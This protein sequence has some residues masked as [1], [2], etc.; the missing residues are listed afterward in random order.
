MKRLMTYCIGPETV[1]LC[2]AV[3]TYWICAR[4]NSGQGRDVDLL[5]KLVMALPF[6]I[7]PIVFA[8]VFVPGARNGWWLGRAV[9][10]TMVGMLVLAGRLISGFGMG[11][12]GQDVAFMMVMIF[13]T[14]GVSLATAITGAMVLAEV[15]PGFAEWFRARWLLGSL[16]TFLAAVPIAATLGI[17]ATVGVVIYAGVSAGI[18]R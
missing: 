9:G 15:R 14:I 6:V 11:A 2:L 12:K 17:I 16:L 7:V 5:E 1:V 4:H 18:K 8:T 13:G 3:A 10:V